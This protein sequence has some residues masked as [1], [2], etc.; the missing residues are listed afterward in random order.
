ML[1]SGRHALKK[2]LLRQ[3][4][5]SRSACYP[6][7]HIKQVHRSERTACSTQS[8]VILSHIQPQRRH[9]SQA[10]DEDGSVRAG[11]HNS[12][13]DEMSLGG[14]A[15]LNLR[16]KLPLSARQD[17][18]STVSGLEIQMFDE[19]WRE[20][21]RRKADALAV[22]QPGRRLTFSDLDEATRH[23]GPSLAIATGDAAEMAVS[24]L[25]ALRHG[26][27]VQ[28]VE[29]DR[30]AHAAGIPPP[31]G[32]ALIKQ[33]VGASGIRRCQFFTLA[34]VLADVERTATA[35][36]MTDVDAIVTPI[37]HSYGLTVGLLQCLMTGYTLHWVPTP[38]PGPVAEAL[39]CHKHSL[40]A[41]VPSIWKAWQVAGLDCSKVARKVSAGAP[42]YINRG[43]EL[44]NLYG[45]SETGSIA[46]GRASSDYFSGA[47]LPG[48]NASTGPSDRIQIQ[49]DAV[50]LGYDV[51]TPADHLSNSTHLTWDVGKVTGRHLQL[52]Q[53]VGEGINV[54]GRKLS[55]AEV[56]EKISSAVGSVVVE[57]SKVTSRDPERYEEVVATVNLPPE[58]LTT[59]F[60]AQACTHLAPWEVP[61]KW[62]SSE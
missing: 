5:H 35:L 59:D 50:A 26:H 42:L 62:I 28:I 60:K 15:N 56:L 3:L 18:V 14:T 16:R 46:I 8:I 2:P 61:R 33:T 10:S 49:S 52:H 41:A 32:T 58:Q 1:T 54:A 57:V 51:M 38:F 6:V 13:Y 4:H 48:V 21:H 45:T 44:W 11:G 12:D 25:R 47:L 39:A 40:L 24:V 37:S 20:L 19:I 43:S 30:P 29:H 27:I 17:A 36:G 31:P 34:Q 23:P 7:T 9:Q 53:C 22:V 55:P